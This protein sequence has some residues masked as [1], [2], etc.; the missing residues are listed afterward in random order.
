MHR[1]NIKKYFI[2]CAGI[3]YLGHNE[4][5][6][7]KDEEDI[8]WELRALSIRGFWLIDSHGVRLE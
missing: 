8:E 5:E 6:D 2:G 7:L 3:K 1:L 4:A